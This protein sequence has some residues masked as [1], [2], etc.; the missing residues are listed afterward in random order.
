MESLKVYT[1][2]DSCNFNHIDVPLPLHLLYCYTQL[3][4]LQLIPLAPGSPSVMS[5][6]AVLTANGW[7][8]ALSEEDFTW[9][10]E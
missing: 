3:K 6:S 5:Y 7:S 8:P 10:P 9:G 2:G 4:P 1:T